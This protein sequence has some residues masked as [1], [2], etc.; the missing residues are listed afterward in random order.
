MLQTG[1][2]ATIF[3]G[4]GFIGRHV[5]RELA[6]LG[7]RIKIASRFPE[8]AY[9]L[10]PCGQTGQIS[11]IYCDY[12]SQE[13]I[14]KTVE[15]ADYV[16][17][18][19]GILNERKKGDFN[20]VHAQIPGMIAQACAKSNVERF[21]HISALGID[22]SNA[23]Y[24]ASKRAGEKKIR[25][26]FPESI[27]LRPSLVF[28]PDDDFFNKLARLS[29][30][31]PALPLIGGGK[32]RFQP[33]YV[34]DI[35]DAVINAITPPGNVPISPIGKTF[36]LGGPEIMTFRDI[37]EKLL[38]YSCRNRLL[39]NVPWIMAKLQASILSCLPGKLL[40]IDQVELLRTDNIVSEDALTLE[41]FG[42]IAKDLDTVLPAYLEKYCSEGNYRSQFSAS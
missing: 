24:A 16:I 11:S 18:C 19:T 1:K 22:I 38:H 40:T 25:E 3:G 8:K 10:Q 26:F 14:L 35:A 7:I 42:I 17:N 6:W 32:T 34:G 5:V 37:I 27:I 4:T 2:T 15:E 9:F 41:N 30:F 20:K 28:G 13:S 33:V 29:S 23:R 21:V 12:S 39:V 31:L 36:Q